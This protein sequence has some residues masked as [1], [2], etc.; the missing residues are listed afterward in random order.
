MMV[1]VSQDCCGEQELS[2]ELYEVGRLIA[3]IEVLLSV[4]GARLG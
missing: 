2:R 1:Q 4:R 3:M